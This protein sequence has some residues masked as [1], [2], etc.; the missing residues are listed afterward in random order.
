VQDFFGTLDEDCSLAQLVYMMTVLLK[1][2]DGRDV[3]ESYP[4][5]KIEKIPSGMAVKFHNG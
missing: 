5:I 3:L 2:E 4:L 1:V